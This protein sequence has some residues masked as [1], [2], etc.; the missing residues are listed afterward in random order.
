MQLTR[1][2]EENP[3]AQFCERWRDPQTDAGRCPWPS[4]WWSG[5]YDSE[6]LL[7]GAGFDSC[8][9]NGDS[10]RRTDQKVMRSDP[11]KSIMPLLATDLG[12]LYVYNAVL[13]IA[14]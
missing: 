12:H 1:R 14:G 2:R 5:A 3:R 11:S 6:R 7:F 10:S 13:A 4:P 8:S 9:G